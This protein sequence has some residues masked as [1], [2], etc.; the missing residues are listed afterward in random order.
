MTRRGSIDWLPVRWQTVLA[1]GTTPYAAAGPGA[2][3]AGAGALP[4]Y[5]RGVLGLLPVV[6]AALY[7]TEEVHAAAGE[8]SEDIEG[9]KGAAQV[10][11]YDHDA[12]LVEVREEAA[13]TKKRVRPKNTEKNYSKGREEY[14]VRGRQRVGLGLEQARCLWQGA[15]CPAEDNTRVH[16][17]HL[18]SW[19]TAKYKGDNT[20]TGDRA[21]IFFSNTA[22]VSILPSH[23]QGCKGVPCFCLPQSPSSLA[24]AGKDKLQAQVDMVDLRPPDQ[25]RERP[26]DVPGSYGPRCRKWC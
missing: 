22:Q 12:A 8:D 6:A 21:A 9:S 23:R 19:C 20:V 16:Q 17:P 2:S 24:T 3:G 15:S 13:E 4:G 26:A 5:R 1:G 18:Q 7:G 10:A 11:K 25:V 14:L